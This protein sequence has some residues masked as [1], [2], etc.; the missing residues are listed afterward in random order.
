MGDEILKQLQSITL[1]EGRHHWDYGLRHLSPEGTD[2]VARSLIGKIGI[3]VEGILFQRLPKRGRD[4]IGKDIPTNGG[5]LW[6]A[7][8][9]FL[10]YGVPTSLEKEEIIDLISSPRQGAFTTH[11][12]EVLYHPT[13]GELNRRLEKERMKTQPRLSAYS[14]QRFEPLLT[15]GHA[16]DRPLLLSFYW[17]AGWTLLSKEIAQAFSFILIAG[18]YRYFLSW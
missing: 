12:W 4:I 14:L 13:P 6:R 8:D 18:R 5:L 10:Q 11:S 1:T 2:E 3:S 7:K 15:W 16:I 9:F 17:L